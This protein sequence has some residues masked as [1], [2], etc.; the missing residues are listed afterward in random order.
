MA[1]SKVKDRRRVNDFWARKARA[2]N[3]PARSVYKLMEVD[4]KFNILRPG[5]RVLDLGCS[6]GSW[7]RYAAGRVGPKGMVIGVDSRP[8]AH[9]LGGP[10]LFIQADVLSLEA[11]VLRSYG[12][13][14]AV[15]SDLA[16]NT[17]GVK[18]VDQARSLELAHAALDLARTVLAGG[19]AFLVKVFM[20]PD[21][22]RFFREMG[23]SFHEVRRIKPESSR[24][25]SFEIFGLGLR[26]KKGA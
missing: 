23:S 18:S 4:R 9:E 22:G 2:E 14:D 10:C 3:F 16:P 5:R 13:F 25:F 21:A 6:P 8:P 12:P 24:S 17:T 15:L 1:G 26:F 19:G 20:G 11:E 7:S